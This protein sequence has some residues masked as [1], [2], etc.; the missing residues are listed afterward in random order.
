ME[1]E[2]NAKL[3]KTRV[4]TTGTLVKV[5]LL[6]V[7]AMLFMFVQFPLPFAP[8]F[9]KV[10]LGDLP[11]LIGGFALG[12]WPGVCIVF[13]KNILHIV[14]QGT[15]TAYVGEISNFIVGSVFV[16]ISSQIYAKKKT[17]KRALIGLTLGTL[18]MTVV[19]TLSN[20]FVIFPL[21]EKLFGLPMDQI[22]GL[23]AKMNG[24]VTNY[25]T[26][27]IFAVAPFNIVK[28]FVVSFVTAVVYK[29]LS[30]ILHRK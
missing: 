1:M 26:M 22:I 25:R 11:A 21:Y 19:A 15:T 6:S 27:M 20:Y 12:T 24:L 10:D 16:I 28:G 4:W 9:L 23:S 3:K 8:P 2:N 29:P 7:I 18:G 30:P 14:A 13:L 5:S 17:K